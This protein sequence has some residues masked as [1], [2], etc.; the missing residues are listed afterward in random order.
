MAKYREHLMGRRN[1]YKG[2]VKYN[3]YRNYAMLQ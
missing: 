3:G 1:Q 2:L